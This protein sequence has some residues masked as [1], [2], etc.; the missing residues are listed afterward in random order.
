M[1]RLILILSLALTFNAQ[2]DF[3]GF[4]SK[5]GYQ[6]RIPPLVEKL[7]AMAVKAD[8]AFDDA[9]NLGVKQIEQGVEEEKLFCSGEAA[10]EKGRTL[11]KEQKQL[12]FR[13]LKN[14]YLEAM[15]TIFD[16]K[17]K[18]LGILHNQHV[19]SLSAIQKK[20]KADIEKNF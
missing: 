19:E 15:D 4:G 11:P 13:E 1:A 10:D 18:Y 5:D 12:C 14:H 2:A 9:F 20:L 16:L 17:K 6:S 3:F 7:K 8:P